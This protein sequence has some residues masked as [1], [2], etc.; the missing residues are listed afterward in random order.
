MRE[1][2]LL[3]FLVSPAGVPGLLPFSSVH[4]KT[5]QRD[6][7]PGLNQVTKENRKQRPLF[8]SDYDQRMKPHCSNSGSFYMV[9]TYSQ[10]AS[11]ATFFL[12]PS[13]LGVT[14]SAPLLPP[15]HTKVCP[16]GLAA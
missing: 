8:S 15:L 1:F 6:Q 2:S 3:L 9:P 5:C 7:A 16:V 12:S 11:E 10:A 13:D 14:L 4:R